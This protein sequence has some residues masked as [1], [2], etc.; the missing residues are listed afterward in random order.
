MVFEI[1]SKFPEAPGIILILFSNP[2]KFTILVASSTWF[3][4][5]PPEYVSLTVI[6]LISK[7]S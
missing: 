1:S 4:S 5:L 6:A 2:H 3:L 7:I